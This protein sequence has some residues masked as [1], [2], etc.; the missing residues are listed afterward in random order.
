MILS[1]KR[2][3]KLNNVE[4]VAVLIPQ[5]GQRRFFVFEKNIADCKMK[6]Q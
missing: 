4:Q 1:E 6:L 5:K 3:L 2:A